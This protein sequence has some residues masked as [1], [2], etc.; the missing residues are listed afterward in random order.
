MPTEDVS[1][2]GVPD[3]YHPDLSNKW[4]NVP[5]L[6][7]VLMLQGFLFKAAPEKSYELAEKP[8][9]GHLY[10]DQE[11]LVDMVKYHPFQSPIQDTS[12]R[13]AY[14]ILGVQ[15]GPMYNFRS[16][17][18]LPPKQQEYYYGLSIGK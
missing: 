16:D 17:S 18:S 9:T 1:F 10:H 12:R 14:A 8:V 13:G 3:P 2:L 7:H 5:P 15:A 4:V 11:C 6:G